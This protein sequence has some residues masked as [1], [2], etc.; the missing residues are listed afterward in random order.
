LER[1]G[2]GPAIPEGKRP[3]KGTLTRVCGGRFPERNLPGNHRRGCS[4]PPAASRARRL[5]SKQ[6]EENPGA[7][8]PLPSAESAVRPEGRDIPCARASGSGRVE[9]RAADTFRDARPD[10]VLRSPG[11]VAATRGNAHPP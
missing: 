6:G 2:K 3:G 5:R 8:P 9:T 4:S 7:P 10:F 1:R 11:T